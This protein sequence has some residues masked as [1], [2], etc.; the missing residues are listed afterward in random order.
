ML[1][2]VIPIFP[3]PATVL[4]PN[5]FLPLYIFEPRYREMV[6]EAL[7]GEHLIGM[8]LLKSG[9][10]SD[11]EGSPPIYEVGCAGLI[12]HAE[13]LSG[14]R[15]NLVLQGIER[16][17]VVGEEEGRVYRR[18]HVEPL[19]ESLTGSD[20]LALEHERSRIVEL[21]AMQ[22]EIAGDTSGLHR[23][24]PPEDFVNTLCQYLELDP[25]E[26]QALLDCDSSLTRA[27]SLSDLLE[28]KK[29]AAGGPWGGTMIQQ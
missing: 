2:P 3:L 21:L 26:K 24:M 20:R 28:M 1:P 11:Y 27:R 16:F 22:T 18:A 15:Y 23:S 19:F 9:W 10:E 17:R 12:T 5:V 13:P 7:G 6:R 4:F 8:V 25:L 14:G 29:L